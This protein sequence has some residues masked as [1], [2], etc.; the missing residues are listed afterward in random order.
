MGRFAIINAPGAIALETPAA[1][2][3]LVFSF[4]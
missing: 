3:L 4:F 1:G 2:E